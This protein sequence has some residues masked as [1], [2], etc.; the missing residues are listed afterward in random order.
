MRLFYLS[1]YN[2][3][4]LAF[5]LMAFCLFCG[6]SVHAQLK[7]ET[8]WTFEAKKISGDKYQLI[9]H[10]K[11]PKSWHIYALEPG[12]DGSMIAPVITFKPTK[13]VKYIGKVTE[14]GKRISMAMEGVPGKVNYFENSVDYVQEAEIKGGATVNGTYSYQICTD[15]MCLPPTDDKPFT[16]K[17]K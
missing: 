17:V 9:V 16:I 10:C 4:N 12:G 2:M 8:K 1:S 14:K 5:I 7:D 13:N 15:Q 6:I 3:K 11:L